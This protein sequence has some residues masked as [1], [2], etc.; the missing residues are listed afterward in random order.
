MLEIM[1][2]TFVGKYPPVVGG[3]STKMYWLAKALGARG[4]CCSVVSDC[5]E[6]NGRVS[7]SLEDLD[8][9]QPKGVELYSTSKKD[10]WGGEIEFKT[11]RLV[12][13]ATET[14]GNRDSDVIVGWYL[15]PYGS[16][17]SIAANHSG[18]PLVLQHAGSDMKRFFGNPNLRPFLIN[19]VDSA[20]GIMAYP[21]FYHQ[22]R[23]VNK[24]VFLNSPKIDMKGFDEAPDYVL[25]PQLRDKKIVTFLGKTSETK[26]AFDLLDAYESM[27]ESDEYGLLY[28]GDGKK[29]SEFERLVEKKG[30]RNVILQPGIPPWRVPGLL[31]ASRVSF[32]GERDF[33]VKQHFSRKAMEAMACGS[34]VIISPEVKAKGSYSE[35]VDGRDCLEIDPRDK[36][37]LANGLRKLLG[38]DSTYDLLSVS[39]REYASSYNSSFGDYISGVETFLNSVV[40]DK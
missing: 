7:L 35:L 26:G 12:S 1:D 9:L 15:L 8:Y 11:E 19:M 32:V 18:L 2:I 14:I 24:N 3:E 28:V 37:E 16:A 30:L 6:G 40:S 17:A 39:G 4:H 27:G 21:S 33:Y 36:K 13:L 20:K 29:K 38:D 34:P 22:F 23:S 25:P 5:Q 10:L 31:R